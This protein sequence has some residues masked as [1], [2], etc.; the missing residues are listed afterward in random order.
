M[1]QFSR[2]S[3]LKFSALT[4]A[5]VAVAGTATGC[6]IPVMKP[7][8]TIKGAHAQRIGDINISLDAPM[9][10]FDATPFFTVTNLTDKDIELSISCFSAE[11]DGT[12]LE[13]AGFVPND[14]KKVTIP[15]NET[16]D[17]LAIRIK[18]VEKQPYTVKVHIGNT[19][20]EY[21]LI[22]FSES[23]ATTPYTEYIF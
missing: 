3:F 9:G 13:V 18:D 2:R 15:A 8:Y 1:K 21:K 20:I 22:S 6:T 12:A 10:I 11:C 14:D 5:A 23:M 17:D 4:A 16:V 7:G 19:S